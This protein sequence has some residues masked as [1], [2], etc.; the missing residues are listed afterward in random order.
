M[1]IGICGIR[2]PITQLLVLSQTENIDFIYDILGHNTGNMLFLNAILSFINTDKNEIEY[3]DVNKDNDYYDVLIFPMA[4]FI[5]AGISNNSK[6]L[7]DMINKFYKS[8]IIVI[9]LGA[10]ISFDS[11]KKGQVELCDKL[12][13]FLKTISIRCNKIYIRCENTKLILDSIGIHNTTVV[14]CPSI[15][16]NSNSKLGNVI[17]DKLNK[18]KGD[19]SSVKL[20]ISSQCVGDDKFKK[21]CELSKLYDAPIIIQ[22]DE[23][24]IKNIYIEKDKSFN[25]TNDFFNGDL[26]KFKLFYRIQDWLKFLDDYNMSLGFR[27]HGTIINII[28]G[29]LGINITHDSRTLGLS[30]TLGIP[31]IEEKDFMSLNNDELLKKILT[32]INFDPEEFNKKRKYLAKVYKD[33]FELYNIPLSEHLNNIIFEKKQ[34]NTFCLYVHP[35]I[36]EYPE[37]FDLHAYKLLNPDLTKA[38]RTDSKI[39]IHYLTDGINEGRK[40]KFS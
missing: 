8:K 10:Q 15:L 12:I 9:G 23:Q 26:S 16:L 29:N 37:D 20:N 5:R 18:L 39:K 24:F 6:Y 33:E 28:N 32:K 3:C 40:Y 36:L 25:A 34:E 1:R 22:D 2:L 38:L 17:F 14:G 7:E 35:Q 31:Y 30:Q 21:I 19:L 27:I 4:N 11:F 13:S